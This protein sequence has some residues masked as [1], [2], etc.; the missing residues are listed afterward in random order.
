MKK[1]IFSILVIGAI[2]YTSF[3]T[4]SYAEEH[5]GYNSINMT[6]NFVDFRL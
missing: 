6:S 5:P 1:F 3:T 4:T 2:L